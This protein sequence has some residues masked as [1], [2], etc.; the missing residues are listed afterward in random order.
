MEDM[1][2]SAEKITGRVTPFGMELVLNEKFR[3]SAHDY[4]QFMDET[5]VEWKE[6]ER[7]HKELEK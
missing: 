7:E 5:V 1:K 4:A 2:H 6:A 3:K